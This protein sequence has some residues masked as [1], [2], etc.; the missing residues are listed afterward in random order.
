[1]SPRYLASILL[2]VIL[3]HTLAEAADPPS[4]QG[5]VERLEARVRQLESELK[6]LREQFAAFQSALDAKAGKQTTPPTQREPKKQQALE[7]QILAGDWGTAP[8]P[9]IQA[10]CRSAAQAIRKYVPD[11]N[12][13]PISV[14]QSPQG[15][16]VIYGTGSAG[17]RR[18][19]LNVK[20]TYWAQFA[21]QFA[22]EFCHILCNYRE[23]QNP[24]LWF[25]ES[26][27]ETASLFALR[28]MAETWKTNP[29]YTNWKSYASALDDYAN[30]RLKN[31]QPQGMRLAEWYRQHAEALRRTG[32]DRAKN[33]VVAAA[34]LELLEDSPQDWPAVTHLNRWD[35]NQSLA[36]SDYLLDWYRRVPDKHKPF[37]AK[38][39]ELFDIELK[40]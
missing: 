13:D 10:V 3:G 14:R 24:N 36:F 20:G 17:E 22:H 7:I 5:K 16:V 33:Q 29:P 38:V 31:V 32:T 4:D 23:A 12:I 27:C 28:Q 6:S 9:N 8:A 11:Q 37:V 39:G 25:E 26:L 35:K 1:M 2:T 19:L 40:R 30:D 34:L 21:F 18:V 15:P